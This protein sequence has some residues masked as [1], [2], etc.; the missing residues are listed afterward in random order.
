[1]STR[2]ERL[3][4]APCGSEVERRVDL[5]VSDDWTTPALEAPLDALGTRH[6]AAPLVLVH[7]HTDAAAT[8]DD[9][10]RARADALAERLRGFAAR[11]GARLVRGAGIQHHALAELGL[12]REGMLVLGNDSHAPT[13]AAD[14]AIAIAAQ[15]TTIAAALHTGTIRLRVPATLRI[16]LHGQLPAGVSVRDLVLTLRA[17]L[18][19]HAPGAARATGRVLEFVGPALAQLSRAERALL[20]NLTPEVAALS[21]TFPAPGEAPW[22]PTDAPADLSLDLASVAPMALASGD[23]APQPLATLAPRRVD[24][25]VVGT[26]AGG[27]LEEIRAF[28]RALS[29]TLAER[30][31][32]GD[33][34]ARRVAVP[35]LVVP[36]SR[37]VSER[38]REEGVLAR[39]EAAGVEVLAPGCG[40]CF[41]FGI[42]RLAEGEVAATTGNRNTRGRLGAVSA[43]A[44]LVAG[45]AA[46]A[47]AASGW[48]GEPNRPA[49]RDA[50]E[51]EA[52]ARPLPAAAP[53]RP[54]H[55][56]AA[57]LVWPRRGNVIRVHGTLT[58][59]DLTPSVVAGIGTSSDTD[60]SVVRRLLFAHLD[61]T[62]AERDLR[63]SV[64][65]G[66]HD[67][68]RGSNRASAVRALQL[69]G[70]TAVIA[71]SVAPLYAAGARD[72]G[73]PI[74]EL[75]DDSFYAAVDAD[76]WV[77]YDLAAGL[78]FVGERR[79]DVRAASPF[80]RALQ[81]AGGIVAY[82][83]RG[84]G[85]DAGGILRRGARERRVTRAT[86]TP[87]GGQAPDDATVAPRAPL[88]TPPRR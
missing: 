25:V 7:D 77:R 19:H 55:D 73:L 44:H 3:L 38:L 53:H 39:L 57:R 5:I 61:P 65:V 70:V 36:V 37:G 85:A 24:R 68:G 13:L 12:V 8:R 75:D 32:A 81:E 9:A 51:A 78:V 30:R 15:P 59:D 35:T 54:R 63:G 1:M 48:L 84:D 72:A 18:S 62:G 10:E 69:A 27:T 6:A 29:R 43:Q 41:G 79:F 71:R 4:G 60:P 40:P 80:E 87:P 76:A 42:G 34:D 83:R 23:G 82:L 20:A 88:Q 16:A 45:A 66:D 50:T 52:V 46:G 14:G 74:V 21:A 22:R 31:E 86:K 26:C 47:A 49:P 2:I 67:L 11:F 56:D 33:A 58:T 28:E 64:L 17:R